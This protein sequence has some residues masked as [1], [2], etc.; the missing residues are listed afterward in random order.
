MLDTVTIFVLSTYLKSEH[1][2]FVLIIEFNK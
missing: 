2:Y 1:V